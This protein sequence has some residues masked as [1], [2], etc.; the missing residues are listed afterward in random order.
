M[1]GELGDLEL[2]E[3]SKL[4]LDGDELEVRVVRLF[5]DLIPQF[6]ESSQLLQLVTGNRHFVLDEQLVTLPDVLYGQFD[7]DAGALNVRYSLQWTTAR[8]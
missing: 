3:R 5:A 2:G 1:I 6:L 4:G 8:L 7:V